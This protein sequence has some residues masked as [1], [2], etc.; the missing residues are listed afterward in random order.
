MYKVLLAD[1]EPLTLIGLQSM[2]VWEDYNL[3]ICGTARNGDAAL[4]LI[5]KLK[6]DIVIIDIKMPCKTGL[7]TASISRDLYGDIPVFIL[8]TSFEEIKYLHG[9]IQVSAVDYLIKMELTKTTLV[10]ALNKACERLKNLNKDVP[11]NPVNERKSLYDNFFLCLLYDLFD[12]NESYE[13]QKKELQIETEEGM[14]YVVCCCKMK[15]PV[16]DTV[17]LYASTVRMVK[18]TIDKFCRNAVIHVD[19]NHIAVVFFLQE[20]GESTEEVICS[21]LRQAAL[22]VKNYFSVTLISSAGVFVDELRLI[23]HSFNAARDHLS[24]NSNEENTGNLFI[25][26]EHEKYK[27]KTVLEVKKYIKDNIRKKLYLTDIA[28]H[29]C[30]TPNY[31]SQLFTKAAGITITEFVTIEKIKEAKK[32][33]QSG[34]IKIYEISDTLGFESA[35]YFSKVFK[36]VTG[37]SPKEYQK[38]ISINKHEGDSND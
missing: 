1:D 13:S 27:N 37:F 29:F 28:S 19:M 17:Q 30:L 20:R 35:F 26:A 11:S 10:N 2:L 14:K 34:D 31:F 4:E 33:L 16:Q 15:G 23:S 5:E 7:E 25:R 24:E 9:A 6:P 8:L 21:A 12:N 38:K 18:E 36:K 32:M 22:I 3:Q